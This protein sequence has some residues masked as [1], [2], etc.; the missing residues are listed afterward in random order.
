MPWARFADD[1]LGNPKLTQLST[2]A[3]ALDMAGIIYSARELRDGHL[4][5]ADVRSVAALI[6]LSPGR[7]VKAATDLVVARRWTVEIGGWEIH[8]YLEYQPSRAQVLRDRAAAAERM[9]KARSPRSSP[10]LP[11][12]FNDPV[13]GPGPGPERSKERSLSS[14]LPPS[15]SGGGA[16]PMAPNDGSSNG[17]TTTTACCPQFEMSGGKMHYTKCPNS[18]S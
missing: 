8:D 9:R 5:V 17:S 6:H 12:K 14:P 10:E 13:P 4:S 16:P 11:K 18:K 15:A 3:I 7:W 2:W 1:F